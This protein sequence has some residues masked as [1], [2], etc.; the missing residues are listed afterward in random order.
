M[1]KLSLLGII[2]LRVKLEACI[3]GIIKIKLYP[4]QDH[5]QNSKL[6]ID[7]VSYLARR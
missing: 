7:I 3:V 2:D 6:G 4:S 5:S 1:L